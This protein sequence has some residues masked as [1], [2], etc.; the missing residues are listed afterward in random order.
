MIFYEYMILAK[1]LVLFA[2]LSA[3]LSVSLLFQS[4]FTSAQTN[5][6]YDPVNLII[7]PIG[8][9]QS[10]GIGDRFNYL[11]M[12][13]GFQVAVQND[14][15][16]VAKNVKIYWEVRSDDSIGGQGDANIVCRD[17]LLIG[18]IGPRGVAIQPATTIQ[19]PKFVTGGQY[20]LNFNVTSTSLDIFNGQPV[21]N[22]KTF[23]FDVTPLPNFKTLQVIGQPTIKRSGPIFDNPTPAGAQFVVGDEINFIRDVS[24][25]SQVSLPTGIY[26]GGFY[27]NSQNDQSVS[28][29]YRLSDTGMNSVCERRVDQVKLKS[30]ELLWQLSERGYEV[31]NLYQNCPALKT[32]GNHTLTVSII[33][34]DGTIQSNSSREFSVGTTKSIIV[35]SQPNLPPAPVTENPTSLPVAVP[36]PVIMSLPVAISVND[37]CTNFIDTDSDLL[38]DK[39]ENNIFGSNPYSSD[40]DG[41]TYADG[42]EVLSGYN[43][44]GSG[45]RLFSIN[46]SF[47]TSQSLRCFEQ[48]V[49]F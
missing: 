31:V 22:W 27:N 47:Q 32:A 40:T 44:V 28:L 11:A 14:A 38:S 19:C 29:I 21:N 7:K 36:E 43:P 39:D 33:S 48:R 34:A 45:K 42:L 13:G 8:T 6:I 16:E 23:Y 30:H 18:L 35:N 49:N 4:N 20:R 41:D 1:K 2:I 9:L 15:P 5:A 25:Q 3:I 24:F 17:T 46:P 12:N 26:K 37:A 10:Y